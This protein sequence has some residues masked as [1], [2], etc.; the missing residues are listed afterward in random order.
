M[1]IV[2]RYIGIFNKWYICHADTYQNAFGNDIN[3]FEN[4]NAAAVFARAKGCKI[5]YNPNDCLQVH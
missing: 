1:L 3:G 5:Y 2:I 4:R